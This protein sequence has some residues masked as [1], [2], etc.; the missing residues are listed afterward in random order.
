MKRVFGFCSAV[1]VILSLAPRI[2]AQ[3][4]SAPQEDQP[5]FISTTQLPLPGVHG[6]FH[7]FAYGPG[8]QGRNAV[9]APSQI[10]M[11]ASGVKQE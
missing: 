5:S 2:R 9:S 7:H 3:K 4:N 10:F 1:I 8:E 6:R 11:A